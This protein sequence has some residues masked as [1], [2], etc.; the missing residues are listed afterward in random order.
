MRRRSFL[1]KQAFKKH[2]RE[3]D[4][5][6]SHLRERNGIRTAIN[7]VISGYDPDLARN[8]HEIHLSGVFDYASKDGTA[9]RMINLGVRVSYF[10]QQS[11]ALEALAASEEILRG[12]TKGQSNAEGPSLT[13]AYKPIDWEMTCKG[14]VWSGLSKEDSLM[15]CQAAVQS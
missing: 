6:D 12:G 2:G 9:S 5:L 14:Q 3:T 11:T 8:A 15:Y 7:R 10:Q 13:T 4:G 1:A